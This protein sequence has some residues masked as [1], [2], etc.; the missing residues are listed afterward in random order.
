MN[1]WKNKDPNEVVRNIIIRKRSNWTNVFQK[2]FHF[3]S[4]MAILS[5]VKPFTD[6]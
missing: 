5:M 6:G 4:K 3:D 2:H 1:Q